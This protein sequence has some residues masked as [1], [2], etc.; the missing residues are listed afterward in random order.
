MKAILAACS[1][2]LL[3]KVSILQV[4]S[5]DGPTRSLWDFSHFRKRYHN[6]AESKDICKA[7][8]K[9]KKVRWCK[10]DIR[11]W[12]KDAI[13]WNSWWATQIH[14]LS[15]NLAAPHALSRLSRQP[16]FIYIGWD[17]QIWPSSCHHNR[18]SIG[19]CWYIPMSSGKLSCRSE[20]QAFQAQQG[21]DP[22]VGFDRGFL[23]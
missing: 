19:V 4:V 1:I 15:Y 17:L 10:S 16:N 12:H 8:R 23:I 9:Q 5:E 21:I 22:C 6:L 13:T 20:D 14:D 7:G 3:W 2:A 18:Q 11:H